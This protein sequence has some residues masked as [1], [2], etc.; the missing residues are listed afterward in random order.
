MDTIPFDE[1]HSGMDGSM[2]AGWQDVILHFQQIGDAALEQRH[3]MMRRL[4]RRSSM[5]SPSW[6]SGHDA[7]QRPWELDP[8]PWV[9]TSSDWESLSA[10]LR[11]RARL[12]NR[13]LQDLYSEQRILK[14]G[15]L[16]PSVVYANPSFARS[17]HG[18][19]IP[20]QLYLHCYTAD[21]IRSHDGQ[22]M[23]TADRTD[24]PLG[25]GFALENRLVFSRTYPDLFRD[26]RVQRIA[27]FF[28]QLRNLFNQLAP[29]NKDNPRVALLTQGPGT[30]GYFEDVYLARYLGY[31]L[32][33]SGDLTVR[34]DRLWLKT[35]GG[36]LPVDVLYRRFSDQFC[37]PLELQTDASLGI[38]GLTRAVRA[39][40]VL[41]AN[42]L[43]SSVVESSAFLPYMGSLCKALLDEELKI[44]SLPTWWCGNPSSLEYVVQ[45][46]EELNIGSAFRLGRQKLVPNLSK[47]PLP[48][49]EREA[50]LREQPLLHIGQEK[51][52]RSRVPSY[53]G[54]KIT[55]MHG[56]LRVYLVATGEDYTVL[57]S[58]LGRVALQNRDLEHDILSG[59]SSK[60]VW[61][62]SN[63]P[64]QPISLLPSTALPKKEFA[65][66]G[67]ELTSR[68]A[69]NLLWLGRYVERVDANARLLRTALLRLARE[70]N[71]EAL[72]EWPGL[73]RQ[74]ADRGL[75]EPGY[76][77]PELCGGLPR[78]T[79]RLPSLAI[80]EHLSGN[81]RDCL[82]Q[83]VRIAGVLRDRLSP[84][85]WQVLYFLENRVIGE[86][87]ARVRVPDDAIGTLS[88]IITDLSAFIGMTAESMTRTLGWRI[89][90]L[91][92]RLE[93][94]M[95]AASIV[96]QLTSREC[97]DAAE[98]EA[99]VEACDSLMTYRFRY[100]ASWS[101]DAVL[102]LIL[103]DETNP[104]SMGY[105]LAS[106][107]EHIQ[108]LA[109]SAHY[110]NN[111]PE[112]QLAN[113]MLQAVRRLGPEALTDALQQG[114][115]GIISDTIQLLQKDL[116]KL[117]EMINARYVVHLGPVRYRGK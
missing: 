111:A 83:V 61:V 36:L 47:I 105:Q 39:G 7:V 1:L 15:H 112:K 117:S 9:F 74:L 18:I 10:G 2:R 38:A 114:P 49:E 33:E 67:T 62:L 68:V 56:A 98:W 69:D 59:Q 20:N 110:G 109:S 72:P 75:I 42:A 95:G 84:D 102:D 45:H 97:T 27:P 94:A 57:P 55:A 19:S 43:G 25:I 108:Q 85:G 103:V 8:I 89:L 66:G 78:L 93:R 52:M 86:P 115:K 107:A 96:A 88:Q 80:D 101:L 4:V 73:V 37:D 30:I 116:L 87:L 91:G 34:D 104:R 11:Q 5:N 58:G 24:A 23:V 54:G 65:R 46:Q 64:V 82:R 21:L 26:C 17:F 32:V 79:E 92:R 40:S 53:H 71:A 60:E 106:I 6:G 77:V 76:A 22:W 113:R 13:I 41:V 28:I 48:P 16:P 35:L 51:A 90:D 99:L 50:I 31:S 3:Q 81:L 44:P 14:Q 63:Q 12:L 100:L 29:A 70:S